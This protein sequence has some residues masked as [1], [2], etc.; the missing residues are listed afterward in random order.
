MV[1]LIL[2]LKVE[3]TWCLIYS[4][5]FE[6]TSK[7]RCEHQTFNKSQLLN[8][9][10]YPSPQFEEE[11]NESWMRMTFP[12]WYR[13]PLLNS[14]FSGSTIIILAFGVNGYISWL[15]PPIKTTAK[16]FWGKN[17]HLLSPPNVTVSDVGTT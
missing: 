8:F 13:P 3:S 17:D 10:L 14:A 7:R 6:R 1:F 9:Q 5:L 12:I 11:V 4:L 15:F 16:N 2:K